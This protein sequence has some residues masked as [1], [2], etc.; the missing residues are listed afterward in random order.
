MEDF[1]EFSE[2]HSEVPSEL[3]DKSII[4]LLNPTE[5]IRDDQ[6][7]TAKYWR[8]RHG[9]YDRDTA[10]AIPVI[11]AAMLENAGCK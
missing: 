2:E 8:I 4:R 1:T 5:Y 3:A 9:A 6:A 7:V 11:L 10:I